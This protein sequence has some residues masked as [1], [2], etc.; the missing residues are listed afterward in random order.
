T[1]QFLS[2]IK[3]CKFQQLQYVFLIKSTKQQLFLNQQ[4]QSITLFFSQLWQYKQLKQFLNFKKYQNL[5]G[6]SRRG[7]IQVQKNKQ[8]YTETLQIQQDF[9]QAIE[10]QKNKMAM[11]III[12]KISQISL[13]IMNYLKNISQ[14]MQNNRKQNQ[15]AKTLNKQICF[16][17]YLYNKMKKK[18]LIR[19]FIK[20]LLNVKTRKII[21]KRIRRKC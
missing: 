2:Q 15:V 19:Q 8:D 17:I 4:S 1:L 7:G 10:N 13:Q 20:K 18:K 3:Y 11:K 12:Q 14:K 6:Y 21:K 5:Y 9:K 16:L